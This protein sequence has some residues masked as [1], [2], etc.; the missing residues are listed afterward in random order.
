MT[1]RPIRSIDASIWS[2]GFSRRLSFPNSNPGVP[3]RLPSE[4][5]SP[6]SN[7]IPCEKWAMI[8]G[9]RKT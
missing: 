8:S 9:I 3:P 1:R 2:P 7:V 4:M 5:T 6:G